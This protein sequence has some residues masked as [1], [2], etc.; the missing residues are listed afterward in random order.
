MPESRAFL[1]FASP[2]EHRT[3]SREDVG[4]Y[5]A[6]VVGAIYEVTDADTDVLSARSFIA[7]LKAC[8][9]EYPFLSVVVRDKDTDKPAY[10]GVSSMDLKEHIS[11]LDKQ[12]GE[13]ENEMPTIEKIL[14]SIL[15]RPWPADIPPW[16][17]VV[18]PL[19]P[20]TTLK[21]ETARCFIAFSFSHT[22]GDGIVGLT[23]HRT[24]QTA[25]SQSLSSTTKD[26]T[27]SL[28]LANSRAL[29][30]PFDTPDRL[31]ITWKY[32]IAPLAGAILPKFITGILGLRASSSP[33]DA[34]AW[35]GAPI[36][37]DQEA[38]DKCSGVRLIE[39]EAPLVASALAKSRAH[40]AKLTAILHQFIVCA[41][42]KPVARE[43]E[44]TNFISGTAVDMRGSI[45]VPAGQWGLFV[46][47][48]YEVHP[49]LTIIDDMAT[50]C[51]GGSASSGLS[52]EMWNS[53]R[54]ITHNLASCGMRLQDQA[55]GL[56]RYAPSIR[57]WTLGKIG[58]RRDC[59][60]EVSNLLAF[61]SGNK[62]GKCRTSKMVFAQ[63]G[64]VLSAPLVFNV[65]SV[66]GGSLVIAVTWQRGALGLN[67]MEDEGGFVEIV[68]D[69]IRAGFE[70]LRDD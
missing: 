58:E 15:D 33:I 52:A 5:N 35:T 64:N 45:G 55:I 36:F 57:G 29:P 42:S 32:L 44:I 16:R 47:G 62:G 38:P 60:Y 53:A 37:H 63:P 25:W 18:L 7:P 20:S 56:L 11:I 43:Q 22:I 39:I 21:E 70:R 67:K 26:I 3:I 30:E 31:P 66:K 27:F 40:G 65:V 34:G 54:I 14:P 59:S 12:I 23:F 41:L 6:L 68:C 50:G 24:F 2:N 17:I 46:T 13:N 10:E 8:V 51:E 9:D 28:C 61:D 69:G 1:R 4:F 48:H 49:R 19:A